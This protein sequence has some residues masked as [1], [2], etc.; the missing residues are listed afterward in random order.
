M[1]CGCNCFGIAASSA[2]PIKRYNL[3]VPDVFPK[4]QPPADAPVDAATARKI[5]RLLEYVDKNP[6]RGPKACSSSTLHHRQCCTQTGHAGQE[7]SRRDMPYMPR[8]RL[9]RT[10]HTLDRILP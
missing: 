4:Q 10:L 5:K 1:N 9:D 2:R 8:E 3:L 7:H 6:Q